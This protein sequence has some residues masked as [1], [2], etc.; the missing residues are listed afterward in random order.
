MQPVNRARDIDLVDE[1][2]SHPEELPWLEFKQDN[3]DPDVIGKRC[4]ALANAARVEGQDCGYMLWGIDDATHAVVGTR[5]QPDGQRVKGQELQLW[6]ANQ[7]QPSIAFTFRVIDH[8]EGRV[9]MLEIPAATTAPIAFK[10]IAY[11]RV[12]STTPK[13]ADYPERYKQLI[14][15]L[16]PYVW[17][18]GVALSYQTGDDVLALIDYAQYFRY[19]RQPLP[20]NRAGIFERLSADRLIERDV[21]ERWNITHLGAMLFAVRLEDFEASLS[22]K[23]VRLVVYDGHNRAATVTH[24]LDG[25]KGYACGFEGLVDYINDVVPHNEHIGR[26]RRESRP[27]FPELAVRELVANALIHQDMT[28]TGA[29]PQIEIFRDRMEITNP[30]RPLIQAERMID[31]PPRSRNETL[32]SL[33]RRM[34]FCEEQGSGLDKVV[35]EVELYQLPPPLFREEGDATQVVLYGPRKFADMTPDERVRAC[36]QHAV[37][38]FLSGGERMKNATLCQ[39]FGI[40]PRNASQASAVIRKTQA[41]GLIKVADPDHPRAGYVPGWA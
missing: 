32:A 41:A 2:R 1:L 8:P 3:I 30:G 36:Y 35:A 33:M 14:E 26:A 9:V 12:G 25:K 5:F 19:T 34:R 37:L 4:S 21:G 13:L 40:D 22:R 20:D 27:L 31:L 10:N 17:E 29:G 15:S 6:L 39:R 24:R 38:K 7:L 16:R 23:A 11:I 28:I 18:Y